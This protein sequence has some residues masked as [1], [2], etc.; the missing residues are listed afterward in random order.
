MNQ[1]NITAFWHKASFEN[2]MQERLP[3]LLAERLPLAGYHFAAMSTYTC[4][5]TVL[6][7]PNAGQ[8]EVVYTDLPQPDAQGV[9]LIDGTERT[10]V[11]LAADSEL[12]ST[13]IQCVGEMLYKLV[14]ER[15]GEAPP[16][17]P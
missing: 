5:V 16:D 14:A 11:P 9:F 8:Q 1:P 10:V 2:F 17:L 4:Q 7:A 13:P 3:Q 12:D 6:L 15:L